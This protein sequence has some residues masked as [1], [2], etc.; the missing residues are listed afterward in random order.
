MDWLIPTLGTVAALSSAIAAASRV[1]LRK[2][3]A[4]KL[5][6][7][8]KG[9]RH[10]QRIQ[11]EVQQIAGA[12]GAIRASL[13]RAE[14]H[15]SVMTSTLVSEA[16]A[17]APVGPAWVESRPGRDY[18]MMVRGLQLGVPFVLRVADLDEDVLV[19]M[20]RAASVDHS[21]I[22]L[23]DRNGKTYY[24]SAHMREGVE[25][26]PQQEAQAVA[27]LGALKVLLAG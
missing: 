23:V 9:R 17:F 1:S 25:V 7:F 15:D 27:R 18:E 12:L 11:S 26:T 3:R 22:Y 4:A 14:W 21:R 19:T 2:I 5:T 16:S 6:D 13:M 20:Y 8:D 10:Q 24:V